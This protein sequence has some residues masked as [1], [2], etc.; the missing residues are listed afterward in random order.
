MIRIALLWHHHQPDYRDPERGRPTMP[1]A[2]LHALRGYRDLAEAIRRTGCPMTVNL[3]PSL[4]DQLQWYAEGGDDPHLALTRKSADALS[5]AERATLLRTFIAGHPALFD[6]W[7]G[8]TRLRALKDRG[9]LRRVGD[10][11]DL[12]VWSTLAWVGWSGLAD[13]P[14]LRELA[15][16]GRGYTEEDKGQLLA[17]CARLVGSVVPLYRS[18]ATQGQVEI[19]ASAAYHPILPLVMDT[20][21][22]LRCLPRLQEGDLPRFSRPEDAAL[23]LQRGRARVREAVGVDISGLWPS[24][25]AVCPELLPLAA[26]A[27]FRWLV[28]DEGNLRRSQRTGPARGGPWDLGHGITGFFRDHDL[29]DRIGFR[30][31]RVDPEAAVD[32]L[33]GACAQAEGLVVLALDGENP[34]ESYPD[35]GRGFLLRLCERLTGTKG[36]QPVTF[37]EACGLPS[38]GAVTH[39]HTGSWINSDFAIWI[40]DPEDRVGWQALAEARDAVA[41]AGDPPDALEHVLAAEGSDWFWW[42]G[43]EFSTPFALE[44]DRLFRAHLAAAWRALGQPPPDNLLL[45]IKDQEFEGTGLRPPIRPLDPP[46]DANPADFWSWAGAGFLDC[47]RPGGSMAQG[48]SHLR[49]LFWG[50]APGGLALR[51]LHR[52]PAPVEPEG[53][54]WMLVLRQGEHREV[55]RWPYDPAASA[56]PHT[57]ACTDVL[58]PL[59]GPVEGHL[60]LAVLRGGAEIARYPDDGA[61]RLTPVEEGWWV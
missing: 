54:E 34:W 24:E 39:L 43:R 51:L 12:Q 57:E 8:A 30:Y 14:I 61:V 58:L 16:R 7:P 40:G 1:W 52:Q 41:E 31:A 6:A 56:M 18:L 22:A 29:S 48:V 20:R 27:G 3:V 32:D 50:W 21:Y 45:P 9:E 26:E 59:D 33:L 15:E 60:H 42:Y 38:A 47:S 10:F 44:F 28:S 23:Q 49:A 2:R 4:L 13:E 55:L 17:A 11:R 35:A 46:M 19:S 36:V 53:A 25:G 5:A 37:S